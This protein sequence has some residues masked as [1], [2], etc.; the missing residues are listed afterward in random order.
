MFLT[1][2]YTYDDYA[3]KMSNHQTLARHYGIGEYRHIPKGKNSK[4]AARCGI[5]KVKKNKVKKDEEEELRY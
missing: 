2:E 5:I 4:N 3:L 1:I